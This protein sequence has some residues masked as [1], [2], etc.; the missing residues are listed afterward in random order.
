MGTLASKANQSQK[1]L[2]TAFHCLSSK[3]YA[4]VSMR[5]IAEEAGVALSQLNYH[6]KTK[7]GLYME[8]IRMMMQQFLLE[9]DE[10]L[11]SVTDSKEKIGS[12]IGYFN[13]LL[14]KRTELFRLFLDFTAQSIWVPNF[15]SLLKELFQNL[16]EII[17]KHILTDENMNGRREQYSPKSLSKLILGALYGTSVQILLEFEEE[18]DFASLDLVE[19]IVT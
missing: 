7:E 17:E 1:I 13:R 3:G 18:H 10:E 12:L 6:F 8:V 4:N 16:S 9:V 5:D 11:K 2:W 14:R 19:M 15:K